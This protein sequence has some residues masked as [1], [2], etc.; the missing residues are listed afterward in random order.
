VGGLK[1][2]P[3][4]PSAKSRYAIGSPYVL[5]VGNFNPHKNIPRL[6]RAFA[7]LPGPVRSRHSLVLAG[8]FGDGRPELAPLAGGL[9]ITDR[10]IFTGRVD[11]AD[12]PALYAEA[13]VCVTPSLEE[14]FGA[15]VLE[16]M[17]C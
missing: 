12:L 3:P 17:A 10:V 1:P 4:P 14:G 7:L 11:D 5:Y 8:G 15:T 13:A 2:A 6:I 16:A 9:V